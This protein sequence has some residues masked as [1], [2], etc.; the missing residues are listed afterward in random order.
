V[1]VTDAPEDRVRQSSDAFGMAVTTLGIAAILILSVYAQATTAGVT[2]DVQSIT[3]VVH[4]ILQVTV[5]L[6][7][8]L[9]TLGVP[10]VALADLLIRRQPRLAAE[11]AAAAIA[12]YGLG[13][14]A[15]RLLA[16]LG[17][18]PLI[19]GLSVTTDRRSII[20]IGL[21]PVA[22]SALLTTVGPRSR[23]PVLG[24]SWNLLW[25]ALAT[26][27]VTGGAT[28]PAAVVSVL[29]GRLIGQATRYVSGVS[30]DRASGRSLVEAIRKAGVSPVRIVRVRDI[31]DP[32]NPTV[33]LDVRLLRE[34]ADDAATAWRAV[35]SPGEVAARA[36]ATASDPISDPTALALERQGGN[37][38]YAVYGADGN[39]WDA[40]V[41]DGDRQVV[42]V[43]NQTWRA[44]RLRGMDRRSVV[45]LRQAAERAALLNYAAA[46]A[47]V[48]TPQMLGIGE[49][50]DSMILL[51]EHPAGLRSLRDMR[52]A[53]I[54]DTTLRGAW[55]Q[56]AKA[57][58]AGLAHRAITSDSVL[59]GPGGAG[60]G[61]PVWL[62]G[63]D[64]G[65][66][67][68]SELA[69]RLDVTQMLAMLA[70]RVGAE[71]AVASA[72]AVLG[73]QTLASVAPLLQPIALPAQTRAEAKER[74]DVLDDLR[75][76]LLDL[77]P[78]AA[79]SEPFRLTRFGWRTVFV[80]TLSVVAVWVVLTKV[81]FSGIVAAV[82][83]AN[84]WWMAGAF[85]LSLTTYVGA[86]MTMVAFAP[87]RIS[88]KNTLLT[89]VAASFVAL[90]APGGIGPAALNL[91]LLYRQRIKT[92]LAVATVALVQV[93]LFVTTVLLLVA[94]SLITGDP[95]VLSQIPSAGVLIVLGALAAV[96]V[97]LTVPPVRAWVWGKLGPTLT[98]VW[99]RLVWVLGKPRR[100]LVGLGGNFVQTIG[101]VLAFW[102][103]LEAFGVHSISLTNA[104][105]IY[106]LGNAAGSA[107]PT[108]GGLGTVEFAITTGLA[109]AGLSAA[110]AASIAV[111]FRALTYWARVPLGWIAW[112][113]LQHH[114]VL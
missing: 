82:Q 71:R 13:F 58:E 62:I 81:N 80:I 100:L 48:R 44:L 49:A 76:A 11:G 43:L 19:S 61:R 24:V 21:F 89:Q 87:I 12:A 8:S 99:P 92:S 85:A 112:R 103:S 101:Y 47:G 69:R 46:A 70:L 88:A 25:V 45:S 57:H 106:L 68:S 4:S 14:L 26:E 37:R 17:T 113:Y 108:P 35:A 97:L 65:D 114:Q 96:G 31:S 72:A 104:A 75:Q 55:G 30:T 39:R 6:L 15:V 20:A 110:L 86:A 77:I 51:Q 10:L 109:S 3:R 95:G 34:T 2:A 22:V 7:M 111:L 18:A 90:A 9:A 33:R 98:Q 53:E 73:P 66:V 56:L 23:R 40:I 42:G 102:A 64:S 105:L 94:I 107:V 41:L 16:A 38:V 1:E 52:A 83:S 50:D 36:P 84:P 74:K 91:R 78:E 54:T 59:S 32:E 29:F 93:S 63:W 67:A 79:D 28:L 5:S 27:I 60:G